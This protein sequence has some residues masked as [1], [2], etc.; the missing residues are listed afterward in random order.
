[1]KAVIYIRV[2]T[3]EQ[4]HGFSLIGQREKC[5]KKAEE[6]GAT[7]SVVFEDAGISGEILHRPALMDAIDLL[8]SDRGYDLFICTDPDRL[9]RVL[10]NLIA[11]TE[12]IERYAK[13][14]FTDF[15]YEETPEGQLFY[16]IRGAIAQFEKEMI[17]RRTMAGK[18]RKAKQGGWT[19]W[20]GI[21]GYNYKDGVVTINEEEAQTLRL[22]F[23]LGAEMG[24]QQVA[25]RLSLLGLL[26]PRAQKDVWSRTTI[27]RIIRNP[28]YY[29]GTTYIRTT[30]SGRSHLNKYR[31][32]DQKVARKMRPREEWVAMPLPPIIEEEEWRRANRRLTEARRKADDANHADYLLSGLLRCG[33]CGKTWHGHSTQRNLVSGPKRARYYVCTYRSPGPP[34]WSGVQK[35]PTGFVNAERFEKQVWDTIRGWLKDDNLIEKFRLEQQIRK[36][37]QEDSPERKMLAERIVQLG[38]EEDALLERLS[39]ESNTRL[40]Q[41]IG[42]QLDKIA[43]DLDAAMTLAAD[44]EK[45]DREMAIAAVDPERIWSVRETLGD[46][47][48]MSFEKRY[49]AAHKILREIVVM[50]TGNE[51]YNLRLIPN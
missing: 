13:L 45:S 19:H 30:D 18:I 44:L 14:V 37:E 22:I 51:E 29:T 47:D 11:F 34:K 33:H 39:K 35:C 17:K 2:S 31:Q 50:K 40:R 20:P 32:D 1:M 48:C 42:E 25:D 5:L 12:Q 6:L 8:S 7:D 21:F 10:G 26:S 9:S 43:A 49:H 23:R 27:Y 36:S 28:M 41:K 24:L 16:S 4:V 15:S 3:E 38:R 46:P